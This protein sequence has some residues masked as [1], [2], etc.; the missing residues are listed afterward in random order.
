MDDKLL[1]VAGKFTETS[2]QIGSTSFQIRK[3]LPFE[4]FEVLEELRAAVGAKLANLPA[5]VS[6][7][8]A[9]VAIAMAIPPS[10]VKSVM[11]RLFAE[12]R[13]SN[14]SAQTQAALAHGGVID[15]AGFEGLE[16]VA[17]Y[18]VFVRVL[19]VN[20]FSSFSGSLSALDKALDEENT[21][22]SNTK[23]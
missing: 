1:S 3:L 7:A 4:G 21:A 10:S 20:F 18:E 9:I 12:V 16:P 23:T 17:V 5:G 14:A 2:F 11:G 13:Y 19:A 22:Q 15:Q 6:A 8:T